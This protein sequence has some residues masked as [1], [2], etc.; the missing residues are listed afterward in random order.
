VA[1]HALADHGARLHVEGVLLSYFEDRSHA[2]IASS[3]GL[4]LGT[5]K[6]RL[7]TALVR[8]R[9]AMDEAR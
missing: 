9:G 7:R 2:E 1:E 5:V 3:L 4:P 6:S 8:L